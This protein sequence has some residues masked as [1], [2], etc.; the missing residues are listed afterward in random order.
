MRTQIFRTDPILVNDTDVVVALQD[1]DGADPFDLYVENVDV[2]ASLRTK[3]GS[4]NA[5]VRFVAVSSAVD[6]YNT[7]AG[8]SGNDISIAITAGVNQAFSVDVEQGPYTPY[9]AAVTINLRCDEDGVPNQ[10]VSDVIDLLNAD[11]TFASILRATRALG[12]DG[13][14]RMEIPDPAGAP[15]VVMP[16][17]YL[18]GGF[19]ATTLGTVTVDVAP[20]GW[21]DFDG[22]WVTVTAAGSALSSVSAGGV[23]SYAFVDA[24]VRG[25]RVKASKGSSDTMVVVTAIVRK[26]G[27]V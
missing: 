26:K 5:N 14:A 16:L 2:A 3:F 15:T 27:G 21:P 9:G 17:T 25:L 1:M 24:P 22:P 12:S 4:K 10:F 18:T 11:A 7:A 8:A 20:T 19:T 23:K 13:S 6:P